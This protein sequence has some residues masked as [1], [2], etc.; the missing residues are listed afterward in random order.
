MKKVDKISASVVAF[1]GGLIIFGFGVLGRSFFASADIYQEIEAV[2]PL[3]SLFLGAL[4]LGGVLI[5]LSVILFIFAA[6]SR[7]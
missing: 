1:I 5:I 2:G 3:Q 4:L 6:T 7:K